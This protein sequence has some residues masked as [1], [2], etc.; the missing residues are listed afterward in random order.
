MA[1]IKQAPSPRKTEAAGSDEGKTSENEKA[2]APGRNN[3][4]SVP[5]LL[6]QQFVAAA[7]IKC[8]GRRL[9]PK[10]VVSAMPV[11]MAKARAQIIFFTAS[12]FFGCVEIARTGQGNP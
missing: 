9:N 11:V 12:P 1:I 6:W 3:Y 4:G 2:E 10:A 5:G 7:Q 8:N